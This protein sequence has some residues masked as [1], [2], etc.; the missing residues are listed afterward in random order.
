MV[1]EAFGGTVD[2]VKNNG[3]PSRPKRSQSKQ[4]Q[5]IRMD[6]ALKD[7]IRDYQKKV[8]S[9]TGLEVSFASAV[10]TLIEKGLEAQ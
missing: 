5:Q 3:K 4:Q 8:H 2:H 6:D 7:R 9:Q 10:R 1:D